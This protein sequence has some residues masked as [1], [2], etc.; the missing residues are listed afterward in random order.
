MRHTAAHWNTRLPSAL[1][2]MPHTISHCN[3]LQRTATHCIALQH[4]PA[5]GTDAI[6]HC[7]H[8]SLLQRTAMHCN[9]LQRTATHCNTLQHTA[10]HCNT[11]L[12]V[13]LILDPL[14]AL[15]QTAHTSAYSCTVALCYRALRSSRYPSVDTRVRE[16]DSRVLQ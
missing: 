5:G 8:S 12:P 14:C 10:T 4:T 16:N 13:A 15:Q 7:V 3:T 2:L 11:L 6:I 9:A 1:V